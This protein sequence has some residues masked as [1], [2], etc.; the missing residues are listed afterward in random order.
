VDQPGEEVLS[1]LRDYQLG[2][3]G[4]QIHLDEIEQGLNGEQNEQ[5]DGN[6]VEQAGISRYESG[7]EQAPDDLRK[8]QSDRGTA[9]QADESD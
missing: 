8:C 6:P 3:R 5:S 1:Q 2:R 9:E 4:E 7:I